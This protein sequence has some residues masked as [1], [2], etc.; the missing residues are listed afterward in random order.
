[1]GPLD[2][3]ACYYSLREYTTFLITNCLS[4]PKDQVWSIGDEQ[5][6]QVAI[7]NCWSHEG[8]S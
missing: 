3:S 1:M 6:E 8:F 5:P 7:E 4:P 2:L